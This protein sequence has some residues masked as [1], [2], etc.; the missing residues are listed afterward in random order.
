MR[1][2]GNLMRP[3]A[4]GAGGVVLLLLLTACG[5]SGT[6]GSADR[7]GTPVA[8]VP[9]V[10]GAAPSGGSGTDSYAPTDGPEGAIGRNVLSDY[11]TW[12]DA[13]VASFSS[14]DS[15][16][17]QLSLDSSGQALSDSLATLHELH[18]AKLVMVGAP[19]T[20][21]VVQKLDL[22]ANPATAVI[23]DCV[24]VSDWHQAD[25][26]THEIKDP[27]PRLTRYLV[28]TKARQSDTGWS[29]VEVDREV[30]RTC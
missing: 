11:Q 2:R 5:A 30:G 28:T 17:I 25:A 24:D 26:V 20:S 21:A 22:K 4:V 14:P 3:G 12:W 16:G 10:T 29:M 19:R 8:S 13:K 27:K 7:L 6:A 23:E 18:D 9:K 1:Q 15:D